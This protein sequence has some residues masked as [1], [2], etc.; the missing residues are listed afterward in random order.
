MS[1]KR[2]MSILEIRIKSIFKKDKITKA[3]IAVANKYIEKWKRLKEL[4]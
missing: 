1:I 2:E 3:D 4:L